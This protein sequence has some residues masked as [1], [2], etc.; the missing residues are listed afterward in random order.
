VSGYARDGIVNQGNIKQSGSGTSN[1]LSGTITASA[2]GGTLTIEPTTFTN[3]GAIDISN[4]DAVTIEPTNFTNAA[5]G[6]I[7][8]GANSTLSLTPGGSWSNEGSITLASGSSLYL[9]GSFTL[10]GLGTLTNSGGAVYIEGTFNN[11][12]GTLNG[13]NVLGQAVLDGGTVQGGTA[14]P[15]GLVLSSS[16]GTLSGVTYDGTLNLSGNYDSVDLASG[17]AVN[18]AAGTGGGTINDTGYDGYLYFD[19]TQTFNN[20]TINLGSTAGYLQLSG[21]L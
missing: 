15:A 21:R 13:T 17:T 9:G 18:N 2:N 20:A 14:T 7:S 1:H 10:A 6:V 11:A 3:N 8:V 16:G 5:A 19:N 4:G 12:G